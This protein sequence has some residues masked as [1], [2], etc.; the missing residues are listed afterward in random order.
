MNTPLLDLLAHYAAR[1]GE[2]WHTPGH[3]GV[4]PAHGDILRWDYDITEIDELL[5]SPNAVDESRRLMASVYG[6]DKTWYSVAGATLPVTAAILAAFPF[7]ATVYVDRA[8]HRSVLSALVIGGYQ[9]RWMYPPLLGA[10]LPLPLTTVPTDFSGV[11]GLVLTRPTYD[12]LAGP[13][14]PWVERAHSHNVPLVVDEA[15]G[16]HWRG[17]SYPLSAL[18]AGADLVAHG[19]HKNEATL[20]GT[21]LLHLK[22]ERVT[23]HTVDRWWRALE[24]SSP[25]YLL[26][27]SLD[28]LQWERRQPEAALAWEQLAQQMRELWTVMEDRGLRVLQPWAERHHLAV[29]PSR[30][31]LLGDGPAIRDHLARFGQVEKVTPNSCTLFVTPGQR[32]EEIGAAVENVPRIGGPDTEGPAISYPALPSVMTIREAWSRTGRW[33]PLDES[34]GLVAADALTP[35]PPGIPMAVP[36]E[37]LTDD[38]IKWLRNWLDSSSGPV[39]G[40]EYQ[41]GRPAVWV[42]TQ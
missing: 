28:R 16:S 38:I 5:Q 7:G 10:G 11:E 19:V 39:Q 12:G 1:K 13:I 17:P 9:V 25:S 18:L 31:T 35:Y 29:D 21:G 2:R 33:V 24:T 37:V 27:A 6:S 23:E 26:L 40:V 30:L 36:G 15:H 42:I 20:T 3:K 41:G 34:R 4:P 14:D 22:G 32:L 8:M